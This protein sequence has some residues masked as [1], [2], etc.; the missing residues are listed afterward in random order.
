M[1]VCDLKAAITV[2]VNNFHALVVIVFKFLECFSCISVFWYI[3]LQTS[4]V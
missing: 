3:A 2:I 4:S 1:L